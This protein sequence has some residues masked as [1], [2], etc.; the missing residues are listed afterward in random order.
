MAEILFACRECDRVSRSEAR[1]HAHIDAKHHGI[2]P[3]NL[4][5]NPLNIADVGRLNDK[6]ELL[7]A[8]PV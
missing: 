6:T 3:F 7:R 5:M 4:I 8:E 1:L 2:G